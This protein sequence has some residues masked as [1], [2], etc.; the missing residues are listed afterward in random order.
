MVPGMQ[1]VFNIGIYV[2]YIE[3]IHGHTNVTGGSLEFWLET[4]NSLSQKLIPRNFK[5]KKKKWTFAGT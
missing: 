4:S 3:E 5:M 1:S 2:V